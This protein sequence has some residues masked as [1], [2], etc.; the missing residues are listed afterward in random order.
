M[1]EQWIKMTTELHEKE[2]V[3][4]IAD[5]LG[6]DEYAVV[7]RLHR[8]WSWVDKNSA[9]GERVR[10]LD[11]R[12]D[13]MVSQNK[14]AHA[15]REVGWL[16]GDDGDATF[17][18]FCRHNGSSAKARAQGA[19][20]AQTSRA[21]RDKNVTRPL[22]EKR[23]E[24]KRRQKTPP[25]PPAGGGSEADPEFEAWWASYPKRQG[26]TSKG[27]KGETRRLWDKLK[28]EER[29]RVV[30]ATTRLVES[31]QSP[32]DAQRFLRPP[33]GGGDSA[34]LEWLRVDPGPSEG[35]S[36]ASQ[37]A[38]ARRNAHGIPYDFTNI[39]TKG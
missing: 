1:A 31:G 14:F 9:T 12:I 37:S 25:T 38:G 20:R 15:L 27:N 6:L 34:Y 28:P 23:R 18:N 11:S 17:P 7:G 26:R 33:R 10:V 19:K 22:P 13:R 4:R 24:E 32:K 39:R 16:L 8:L 2:E 5:L 21:Q 36:A 30:E 29:A 35:P 3:L